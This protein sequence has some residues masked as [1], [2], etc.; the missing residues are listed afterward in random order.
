M[1][2]N[3]ELRRKESERYTGIEPD[4][5]RISFFRSYGLPIFAELID[6]QPAPFVSVATLFAH[7][8]FVF[9]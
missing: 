9:K 1:E 5:V 6:L 4:I 2:E 3:R 8:L 7:I